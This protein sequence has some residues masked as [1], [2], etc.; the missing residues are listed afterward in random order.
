MV[1]YDANSGG[2]TENIDV[3]D[4]ESGAGADVRTH[5]FTL[6]PPSGDKSP[7]ALTLNFDPPPKAAPP[8]S[9]TMKTP[10]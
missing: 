2:T 6:V 3:K 9:P 4:T 10:T 8:I 5:T 7:G 1:D